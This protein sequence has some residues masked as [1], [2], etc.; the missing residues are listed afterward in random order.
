MIKATYEKLIAN[1]VKDRKLSLQDQ[2]QDKDSP[3]HH[4]YSTE[5]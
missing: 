3:F 4:F 1:V 5:Y 2:K